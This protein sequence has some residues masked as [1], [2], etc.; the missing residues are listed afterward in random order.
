MAFWADDAK[1]NADMWATKDESPAEVI[2][3]YRRVDVL[4]QRDDPARGAD[5]RAS[6][7]WWAP[8]ET[9]LHALLVHIAWSSCTARSATSTSCAN[10]STGREGL[11]DGHSDLPRV[12]AAWW[13]DLRGPAPR[14][15]RRPQPAAEAAR[16]RWAASS[17]SR[18]A[19]P[20]GRSG[21]HPQV[22][23]NPTMR[24][25]T[26]LE[27]APSWSQGRGLAGIHDLPGTGEDRP[28]I[29][30]LGNTRSSRQPAT[31]WIAARGIKQLQILAAPG[32]GRGA[33]V[34]KDRLAQALWGRAADLGRPRPWRPTCACSVAGSAPGRVP[35][36][37]S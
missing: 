33:P 35:A 30:L 32:A 29:R 14:H 24:L 3:V 9:D 1:P 18:A 31:W 12:D 26:R 17:P 36:P 11:R 7:P 16:A 28:K 23:I 13:V 2:D 4:R 21:P 5:A 34:T 8:Q 27:P 20:D 10:S 6:V 19:T 15:R 22:A 37:P 25:P